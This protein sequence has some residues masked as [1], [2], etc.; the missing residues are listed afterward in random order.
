MKKKRISYYRTGT[1]LQPTN[2]RFINE[3]KYCNS[4]GKIN[5]LETSIVRYKKFKKLV[6][7][8]ERFGKKK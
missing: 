3:L 2:K 1:N 5:K 8:Y 6:K 7:I 4:E